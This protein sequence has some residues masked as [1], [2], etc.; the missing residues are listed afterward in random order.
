[1]DMKKYLALEGT[2]E[3][4]EGAEAAKSGKHFNAACPYT[5]ASTGDQ[6]DRA[7]LDA[8]FAGWYVTLRRLELPHGN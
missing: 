5:F 8:W 4:A 7:K 1:M 3:F 2:H 6:F